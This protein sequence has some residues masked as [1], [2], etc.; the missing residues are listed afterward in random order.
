MCQFPGQVPNVCDPYRAPNS[1]ISPL[2]A[3]ERLRCDYKYYQ[4]CS[5]IIFLSVYGCMLHWVGLACVKGKH[6]A[7]C[8]F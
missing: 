7:M 5:Q 1:P 3:D 4:D 6:V 8:C 2:V